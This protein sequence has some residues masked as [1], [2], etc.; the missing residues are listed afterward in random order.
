MLHSFPDACPRPRSR[1]FFLTETVSDWLVCS[2]IFV[3]T[4]PLLPLIRPLEGFGV[5]EEEILFLT[6]EWGSNLGENDFYL[7]VYLF[8]WINFWG[9][10]IRK[11]GWRSNLFIWIIFWE[12][13]I[14]KLGYLEWKGWRR[15]WFSTWKFYF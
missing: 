4:A 1:K 10:C 3:A 12:I 7:F 9:I 2:I 5:E 11:L 13:S 8:I 6:S 15:R 14:R